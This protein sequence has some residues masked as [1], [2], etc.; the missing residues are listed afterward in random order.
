MKKIEPGIIKQTSLVVTKNDLATA[1]GSGDVEVFATPAMI[2]LMERTALESIN[3]LLD[4]SQT[5][6]GFEVNVRHFKAVTI[7]E[8]VISTASL[9]D[10]QGKKL[11]F[12]VEVL[13][14]GETVGKGSHIRYIVD[15]KIFN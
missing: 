14:K 7:G 12:E 2:T 11:S 13:H 1:Y 4:S 3:L 15:K 10:V 8:E 5:T 6:V 9:I